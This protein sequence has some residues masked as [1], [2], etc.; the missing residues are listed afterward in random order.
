MDKKI[1]LKRWK[2]GLLAIICLLIST[3][4]T[5]IYPMFMKWGVDELVLSKDIENL[6][7]YSGMF[8]ILIIIE[9]IL[10][11]ISGVKY[12]EF[13]KLSIYEIQKELIRRLFEYPLEFFDN[14]HSGYLIGRIRGDV[15]GLSY[16]YSEGLLTGIMDIIRI[17]VS[18]IILIGMNVKL[19]IIV[20]LIIPL[21]VYKLV[22]SRP[23]ISEINNQMMEEN[24][25]T[26][27]ELSDVFQGIEEYKSMSREDEGIKRSYD[28]L[29][30]Y[31]KIQI[32]RN[33]II[34]SYNNIIDLLIRIGSLLFFYF[35]LR[36]VISGKLSIGSFM[37]FNGYL[38]Y[39]YSPL[40][41][42]SL[43]NIFVEYARKSYE[44]VKELMLIMTGDDKG[45][46]EIK[47]IEKIEVK[48]LVFGYKNGK[49]VLN[50]INTEIKRG[51]RLE[52]RGKS[53]SGKSTL[54]KLLLGLYENEEGE[55][56]YNGTD[57]K[58]ISKTS[59]RK[60]IGYVTQNIFLFKRSIRENILL[61][62]E[63]DID[64]KRI[65]EVLRECKLEEKI[66][67]LEGGLD[68][69]VE[70]KGKNFSGGER[71]RIALARAIIKEPDVIILDE[72]TSNIDK[73]TSKE[74]EEMILKK[75]REKVIIK[76]SH[77]ERKENNKL[78]KILDLDK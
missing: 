30:R 56:R 1:F 23:K 76:I 71:Q 51:E 62:E 11:Y 63:R 57:I 10:S 21:V 6:L 33:R 72:A 39:M 70:E 55:I 52:I 22:R 58:K 69:I 4:I 59:I 44:R 77:K 3:L 66:R 19:T 49:K 16:L 40:K 18:I 2:V 35:G 28:G 47:E 54:V 32:K 36:E 17:V 9:R 65:M 68:Y 15:E 8:F 12:F 26:E 45:K 5:M 41:T 67:S 78:W 27:E 43:M 48:D 31:M 53:G 64:D 75:F 24:A 50:G 73:E 29:E 20:S 38:M 34:I 13:Q 25:K 42:I 74:I 46:D 60:R 14:K 61:G 7:K 37:A